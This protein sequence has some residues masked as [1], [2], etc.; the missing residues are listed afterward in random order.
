MYIKR[1]NNPMLLTYYDCILWSMH[2]SSFILYSLLHEAHIYRIL[3]PFLPIENIL[4]RKIYM[5][6]ASGV[7]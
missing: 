7:G 3:N 4:C 5:F 1:P 6:N 2:I